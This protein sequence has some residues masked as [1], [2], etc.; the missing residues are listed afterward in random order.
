MKVLVLYYSLDGNTEA[1]AN[2]IS[3]RI[4]ADSAKLVRVDR[5]RPYTPFR[6][7]KARM[8][9]LRKKKPG[10]FPFKWDPR[11]YDLIFIGTPVWFDSY[12]PV[13]NT[14]FSVIKI[15]DRKIALFSCGETESTKALNKFSDLLQESVIMDKKHLVE[16]I[17]WD[18][19]AQC[20]AALKE[21]ADWAQ[22]VAER[23]EKVLEEEEMNR[24]LVY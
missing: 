14:L 10:L 3:E 13:F 4:G 8:E 20:E 15:Y 19:D 23:T 18:D 22:E 11:D 17:W 5:V 16:P 2:A 6:R 7:F 1:V 9:V 24:R 12:N 21:A